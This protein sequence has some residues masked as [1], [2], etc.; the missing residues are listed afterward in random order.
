[1]RC[2]PLAEEPE[3]HEEYDGHEEAYCVAT[4]PVETEAPVV[5][6]EA[7]YDRLDE[8]VREAHLSYAGKWLY[9]FVESCPVVQKHKGGYVEGHHAEAS[10]H[11][12]EG[13]EVACD[14]ACLDE[15]WKTCLERV[16]DKAGHE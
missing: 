4:C 16:D 3:E 11:R 10:P 13:A 5:E 14:H 8:V 1:M 6:Q 12:E 9:A 2:P 7:A 15:L